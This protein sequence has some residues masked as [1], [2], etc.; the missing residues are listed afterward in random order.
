M[1]YQCKGSAG[2]KQEKRT[3]MGWVRQL[4]CVSVH[5]WSTWISTWRVWPFAKAKTSKAKISTIQFLLELYDKKT[6]VLVSQNTRV[7]KLAWQTPPSIIRG[8]C[9]QASRGNECA[10]RFRGD[11]GILR[12]GMKP[13]TA[14]DPSWCQKTKHC[15]LKRNAHI[16]TSADFYICRIFIHYT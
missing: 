10:K 2:R 13:S 14:S 15:S 9:N 1:R 3:M 12:R 8:N 4:A 11:P 7:C 5:Y 16:R 6:D